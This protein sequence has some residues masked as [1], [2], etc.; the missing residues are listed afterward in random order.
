MTRIGVISDTHGRPHPRVLD[1]LQGVD[2]I[3]HA[4]DIGSEDV[5]IELR[6]IAPVTA[7]RGNVDELRECGRYPEEAEVTLGGLNIHLVHQ[8]APLLARLRAGA[9]DGPPPNVLVYGHSHI[10]KAEQVGGTLVFNPGSAGPRRFHTVPSVGR[11][12][13]RDG[14]VTAELLALNPEDQEALAAV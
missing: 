2:H 10:G 3:L 14:R 9:W 6:A 8:V 5:L 7:V 1:R 4:G 11:L 12:T 13:V